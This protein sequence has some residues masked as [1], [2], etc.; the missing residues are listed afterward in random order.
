MINY[1]IKNNIEQER[2]SNHHL[3]MF[4]SGDSLSDRD[5]AVRMQSIPKTYVPLIC[6]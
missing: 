1:K 4:L 3:S 2:K 5:N 6:Y